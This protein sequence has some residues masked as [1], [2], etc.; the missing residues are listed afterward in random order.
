MYILH[1]VYLVNF[2]CVCFLKVHRNSLLSEPGVS[3]L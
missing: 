2:V 1:V 3:C